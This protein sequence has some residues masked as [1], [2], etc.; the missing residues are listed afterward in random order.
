MT[1]RKDCQDMTA[2]TAA[3]GKLWTRLP[4]QGSQYRTATPVE[5]WTRV[6]GRTAGPGQLRQDSW[7]RTARTGLLGKDS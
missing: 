1:E 5:L 7:E 6:L 4:G 2:K 3:P